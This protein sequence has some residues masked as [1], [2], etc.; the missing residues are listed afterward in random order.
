MM[1]NAVL[2]LLTSDERR[3]GNFSHAFLSKRFM[4]QEGEMNPNLQLGKG[5]GHTK[6]YS[7]ADPPND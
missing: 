1:T 6:K 5:R 4:D 7:I 3:H 2:L